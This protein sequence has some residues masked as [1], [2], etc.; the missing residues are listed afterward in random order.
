MSRAAGGGVDV[1]VRDRL[2]LDADLLALD[3]HRL[4]D[5]VLDHVLAQAG[6]AGL[7][8][9]RAD[10]QLLL[11]ARHRV[12]GR[13]AGRVAADGAG[14]VVRRPASRRDRRARS[15]RRRVAVADPVVAVQL[16]LLGA[17][18]LAVRVHLRRVLH[19]RLVV[20]DADAAAVVARR[21]AAAR[22]STCRRTCPCSPAPT[23]ARRSRRRGRS[24]RSC[25]SC[26][27][28]C[29][30]GP[31]RAAGAAGPSACV[32]IRGLPSCRSC[33]GSACPACRRPSAASS[34]PITIAASAIRPP[35]VRLPSSTG[36]RGRFS[37][38]STLYLAPSS[39]PATA[40]TTVTIRP[41][42]H[43]PSPWRGPLKRDIR[44]A[45]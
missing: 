34:V 32:L 42:S 22:S 13:R 31:G 29:R 26:R 8:L 15:V 25:R 44:P 33:G 18:E 45:T 11:G 27:R 7:P 3:G 39:T 19:L 20:R 21:R 1:G 12:V 30:T 36:M 35:V 16:V 4:G 14:R 38:E 24:P 5:L 28:C 10:A 43:T 17:G 23:R 9:G 40:S 41:I 2:A 6:A 37:C